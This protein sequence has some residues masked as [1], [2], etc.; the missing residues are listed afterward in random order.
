MAV[1]TEVTTVKAGFWIRLGAYVVDAIIL[2]VVQILLNLALGNAA[3]PLGFLAGIAYFVYFWSDMGG[4]QT[5]GMRMFQL[6]VTRTDGASLSMVNA[7]VRYVGFIVAAIP[8]CIGLIWV[9]FDAEKQGWHDK[10]AGTY[11]VRGA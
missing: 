5:I 9:A 6:K 2:L 4:G 10:I 7:V 11:V 8:L 3:G 1:A